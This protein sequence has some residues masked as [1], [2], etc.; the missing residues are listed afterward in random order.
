MLKMGLSETEFVLLD[1]LS[2]KNTKELMSGFLP[3]SLRPFLSH[4]V[5]SHLGLANTPHVSYLVASF[6]AVL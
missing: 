3:I 2:K 1:N 5:F 4:P 6:V